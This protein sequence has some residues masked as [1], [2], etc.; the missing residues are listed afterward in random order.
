MADEHNEAGGLK[1]TLNK[2]S[3]LVGGMVGMASASTAGAHD[4]QAFVMNA[5][6]GD[7][8]EIEAGRIA[9][10][11]AASPGVREFGAMMV[12]HHTTAMHQMQSAL[13]SSE[14]TQV[15][16]NLSP[17]TE[18]DHRRQGMIKHLLEAPADAFDRTYLD[19]QKLA[20]QETVTLHK[21]YAEHGE[22]PQLRSVALGGLPM[23]ERHLKAVGQI[24]VH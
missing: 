8:Y 1:A 20:H 12:E 17:T 5:C 16:P 4:S 9:V 3:D 11:R 18:L 2:A 7:L 21:G 15:L 6:V 24:G 13:A 23:V 10:Q 19:Q 14:V 22:N